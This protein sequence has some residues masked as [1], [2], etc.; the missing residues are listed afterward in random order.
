MHKNDN[1]HIRIYKTKQWVSKFKCM[2]A[3]NVQ[4]DSYFFKVEIYKYCAHKDKF[5]LTE[6]FFY[7]QGSMSGESEAQNIF[8]AAFALM[9]HTPESSNLQDARGL[10]GFRTCFTCRK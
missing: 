7:F 4:I 8:P 9:E 6:F 1:C 3:V 10:G 5:F 2:F